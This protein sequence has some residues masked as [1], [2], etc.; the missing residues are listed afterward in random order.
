MGYIP[1]RIIRPYLFIACSMFLISSLAGYLTPHQYQQEIAKTLLANFS[2]MQSSTRLQFFIKIFLNNYLSTLL[3]L[4]LGLLFC[5]GPVLFLL[6]NG[7][8]MGNLVA[9]ASSKVGIYKIGLAI[10][11]HGIFE[12]PAVLIASSYGLWWGVKNYRRV[13]CRDYFRGDFALPL[14]RYINV[15]IPLLLIAA[16]VEA[17]ITPFIIRHLI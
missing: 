12:V 5:I 13:R 6:I 10:V 7:F 9:F 17:Y 3:T 8:S 15:V 2:P 1:D 14:N 11:P 16:F 4:L